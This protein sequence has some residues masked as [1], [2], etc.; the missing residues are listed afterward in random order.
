[1]VAVTGTVKVAVVTLPTVVTGDEPKSTPLIFSVTVPVGATVLAGGPD[2]E[3]PKV[4]VTVIFVPTVGARL[5]GVIVNVVL[6]GAVVM[7]IGFEFVDA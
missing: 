4:T 1:M 6:L 3:T 7:V 5:E 2:V